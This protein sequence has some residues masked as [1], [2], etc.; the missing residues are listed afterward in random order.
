[1]RRSRVTMMLS[2][3]ATASALMVGSAPVRSTRAQSVMMAN[4]VEVTANLQGPELFWGPEGVALGHDE[5]DIKGYDNFG[6]FVAAL[7]EFDGEITAD[8][9]KYHVVEGKVPTSA[10]STGNLKTME[11]SSITYNRKFRKDFLDDA[12]VGNKSAGPSKSQN[13]PCDAEA[14]NGIVHSLNM[15]LVPGAY[16]GETTSG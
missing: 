2:G 5:S 16:G 8:V 13:F 3:I 4:V 11:G 15:V 14:D 7:E 12:L 1:M 6:K 9:L 10:L